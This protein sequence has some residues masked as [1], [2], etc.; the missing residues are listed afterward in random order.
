MADTASEA[1][2]VDEAFGEEAVTDV[3]DRIE[4]VVA[5]SDASLDAAFT[6]DLTHITS[7]FTVRIHFLISDLAGVPQIALE[8]M[9]ETH[10][11]RCI[12]IIDDERHNLIHKIFVD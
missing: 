1:V 12:Y 6:L 2:A 11:I 7:T 9:I 3:V 5:A 4:L 10:I 8:V